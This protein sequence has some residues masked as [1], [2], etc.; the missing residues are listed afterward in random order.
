M[1]KLTLEAAARLTE[2]YTNDERCSVND[3]LLKVAAAIR[4]LATKREG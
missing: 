4:A 1:S 2:G 3:L